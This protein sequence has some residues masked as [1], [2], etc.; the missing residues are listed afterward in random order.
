MVTLKRNIN[1]MQRAIEDNVDIVQ[2]RTTKI[3]QEQERDL[4]RAFRARL[5]D[6]QTELEQEKSRT[7]NGATE[8]IDK[9]H[10]VR[11]NG[12]EDKITTTPSS[13]QAA[14]APPKRSGDIGTT[15]NTFLKLS[16]LA[17]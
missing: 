1:N 15:H 2:D 8:H 14:G 9:L 4:L 7:D 5:F 11:R 6:V 10:K 12:R 13:A 16:L 17:V 3:L